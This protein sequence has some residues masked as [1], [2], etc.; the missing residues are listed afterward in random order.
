[1]IHDHILNTYLAIGRDIKLKLRN[2]SIP[3]KMGGGEGQ[4]CVLSTSGFVFSSTNT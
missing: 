3:T 4:K 2:L 1:M